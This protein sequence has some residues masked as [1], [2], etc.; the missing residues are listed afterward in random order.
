M[1]KIPLSG[2]DFNPEARL[3][4]IETEKVVNDIKKMVPIEYFAQIT[5]AKDKV[6]QKSGNGFL[7]LTLSIDVA[8]RERVSIIDIL[9]YVPAARWKITDVVEKLNL[10]K[11]SIDTDDFQSL[12][13]VVTLGFREYEIGEP[14][15]I[16]GSKRKQKDNVIAS[17]IRLATPEEVNKVMGIESSEIHF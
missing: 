13:C 4:P 9:S 15:P 14:D 5:M 2:D 12:W 7:E 16:T 10:D 11:N 6:S 8:G 3:L 17:Y 1:S